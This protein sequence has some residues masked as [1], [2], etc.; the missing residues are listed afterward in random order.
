MKTMRNLF[1]LC[2]GLSLFACSSDDD[3]TQQFPEGKGA[4]TVKIVNPLSRTVGAASTAT[5]V[6]NGDVTVTLY[7]KDGEDIKKHSEVT[8]NTSTGEVAKFWDVTNPYLVTAS[9]HGGLAPATSSAVTESVVTLENYGNIE[10]YQMLPSGNVP[11]YG[12]TKDFFKTTNSETKPETDQIYQMYTASL[13]MQVPFAR[14]EFTVKR[15]AETSGFTSLDLGGVYLDNLLLS[16]SAN[17]PT[18]LKH[19]NDVDDQEEGFATTATGTDAPLY[20]TAEANFSFTS[21][22]AVAPGNSE[23]YAYNIFPAASSDMPIFKVWF[24]NATDDPAVLPYQYAIID[25]YSVSA[26]E[27]GNIYTI[28]A[29]GLAD[30]NIIPSESGDDAQ[31][32]VNVIVTQASWNVVP[33]TATWQ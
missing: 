16:G 25:T 6:A 17:A 27:A 8:I 24:N 7:Y 20:D 5:S 13:T 9:I 15:S 33:V 28:E 32:G 22:E 21:A 1:L 2:A 31:F 3:A 29:Y 14:L 11:A 19:P 4:V 26:F 18:D 23:V 30:T 12:E 10:T